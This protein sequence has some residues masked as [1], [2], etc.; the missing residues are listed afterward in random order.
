LKGFEKV[1]NPNEPVDPESSRK[2]R[3]NLNIELT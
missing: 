1:S 3:G 2:D